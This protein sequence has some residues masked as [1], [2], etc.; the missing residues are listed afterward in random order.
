MLIP[1]KQVIVCWTELCDSYR[2]HARARENQPLLSE[3]TAPADVVVLR[4]SRRVDNGNRKFMALLLETNVVSTVRNYR[5]GASGPDEP[6]NRSLPSGVLSVAPL[7]VVV[8][9][10]AR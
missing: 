8:P 7:A 1:E 6:T 3:A 9:S 10:F 4:N 5:T 2:H